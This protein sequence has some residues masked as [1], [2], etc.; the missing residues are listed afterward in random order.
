MLRYMA[1]VREEDHVLSEEILIRCELEEMER[2][3]R[4]SRLRVFGHVKRAGSK[5][6][7]GGAM[8]MEVSGRRPTGKPRKRWRM[9]IEDDM[10]T[11]SLGRAGKNMGFV[12]K[13]PTCFF[14]GVFIGL[15]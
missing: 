6:T 7:I 10:V 3:L 8:E 14:F 11:W 12:K 2:R 9:C 1:G 15:F 4:K 13:N 5:S